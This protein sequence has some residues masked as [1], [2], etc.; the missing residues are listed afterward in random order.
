MRH[1][2]VCRDA[3]RLPWLDDTVA[4][5]RAPQR[6][7]LLIACIAALSLALVSYLVG[8]ISYPPPQAAPAAAQVTVRL[9]QPRAEP[10]PAITPVETPASE[11]PPARP[12]PLERP[13]LDQAP[14]VRPAT[15]KPDETIPAPS[16]VRPQAP[17][18]AQAA[19]PPTPRPSSEL[20]PA[21]I[22][23]GAAGRV[24]RIGTFAT[25]HKAKVAWTRLVRLYPGVRRLR[26][27]VA[28]ATSLRNG[29]TYYRLQFGTTSQAHSEVLC[30]RMRI[31]GQSCVVVG[32]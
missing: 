17:S 29:R 14:L 30:Q 20:W 28:P 31:I 12:V 8:R 9:E 5:V 26:A 23:N 11:P 25:R 1:A 22:S 19:M 6:G 13:R 16:V 21:A 10:Q 3:D 24:A 32:V 18:Q 2:R 27:V 4:P 15:E 7:W